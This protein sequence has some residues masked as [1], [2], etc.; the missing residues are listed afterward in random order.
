MSK[1]DEKYFFDNYP[2]KLNAKQKA[3]IIYLIRKFNESKLLIRL[4]WFA[5]ILA[6]MRVETN[7]T[8]A[9]VVEGYY[10]PESRRAAALYNYYA[11]NNPYALRTIFPNGKYGTN[12]TGRGDAQITHI[13]N[14]D[15]FRKL[16]LDKFP[17]KDIV[18][19]PEYACEPDI[20]FLIMEEGMTRRD[21]TLRDENF[22]GFTLEQFLNDK[23]LDWVGAR[24]IINGKDKAHQIASYAIA[25]YNALQFKDEEK[26]VIADVVEPD[27][28][29]AQAEALDAVTIFANGVPYKANILIS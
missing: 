12:Y 25:I 26:P 11:K 1:I 8:F 7:D 23:K 13:F 15:K 16:V 3:N 4:S 18:K 6:T 19:N 2:Y 10:I 5:Y 9:P 24:K 22:T 28:E 21:L 29:L 27:A 17:G 20:A 14:Y